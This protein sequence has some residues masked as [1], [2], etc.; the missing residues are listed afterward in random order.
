MNIDDFI[1]ESIRKNE[2]ELKTHDE[3]NKTGFQNCSKKADSAKISEK[4]F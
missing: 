4:N 3:K 2:E 1:R